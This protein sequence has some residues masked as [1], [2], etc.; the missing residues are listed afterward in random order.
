[1]TEDRLPA[2]FGSQEHKQIV[3][4]MLPSLK[5]IMTQ[6]VAPQK[7]RWFQHFA[8]SRCFMRSWSAYLAACLYV[9]INQG[10]YKSLDATP[11]QWARLHDGLPPPSVPGAPADVGAAASSSSAHPAVAAVPAAPTVAPRSVRFSNAEIDKI[12]SSC[13]TQTHLATTIM[14]VHETKVLNAMMTKFVHPIEEE[15][16]FTVTALKTQAGTLE[17]R[18]QMAALRR[19]HHIEST[20]G[21]LRDKAL[22]ITLGLQS[23]EGAA[24]TCMFPDAMAER[25]AASTLDFCRELVYAELLL[26][27]QHSADLPGKFA[28][29]VSKGPAIKSDTMQWLKQTFDAVC[30]AERHARDDEFLAAWLLDLIWVKNTWI[31]EVLLSAAEADFATL[32]QDTELEV[33]QQN[34][35]PVTTKPVEDSFNV[36]RKAM[37]SSNNCQL[38]RR[39]LWHRLLS[40]NVLEETDYK[41][42]EMTP[43]DELVGAM[44]TQRTLPK[45]MFSARGLDFTLGEDKIKEYR[46]PASGSQPW[47][48]LSAER[49][50][51]RPLSLEALKQCAGDYTKLRGVWCSLLAQLDRFVF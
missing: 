30:D 5:A 18:T 51:F 25:I 27:L 21:L 32:P 22:L 14:C 42:H 39:G 11:W 34:L 16:N 10:Y 36:A 38:S 1:M 48:S 4:N 23:F 35:G 24:H 45:S 8:K 20:L 7:S 31:R 49:F 40:S 47:S 15:H 29:A 12:R 50:L 43:E 3:W 2:G 13:Q 6:G 28:G 44:A 46:E 33:L 19:K 9:C 41:A 17:W 26:L 37:K